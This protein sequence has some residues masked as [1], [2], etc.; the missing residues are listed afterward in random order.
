MWHAVNEAI[1]GDDGLLRN[2][3]NSRTTGIEC[4]VMVLKA[5]R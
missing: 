5:A 2:S 3:V 4:I 1:G